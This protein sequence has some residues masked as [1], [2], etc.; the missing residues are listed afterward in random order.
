[1]TGVSFPVFLGACIIEAPCNAVPMVL[2]GARVSSLSEVIS[3]EKAIGPEGYIVL[4]IGLL[5][6][7]V[8]LITVCAMQRSILGDEAV[9]TTSQLTASEPDTEYQPIQHRESSVHDGADAAS[10]VESASL[11]PSG[12]SRERVQ[13]LGS[14]R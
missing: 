13:L 11:A 1:V 7:S 5:M 9:D 12:N 2:I 14:R 4:G 3:G 8:L 10:D 6:L